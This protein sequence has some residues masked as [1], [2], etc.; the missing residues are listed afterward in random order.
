MELSR[1]NFIQGAGAVAATAAAAGTVGKALAKESSSLDSN[2]TS[3]ASGDILTRETLENGTWSFM[4]P[5]DPVSDD[6]ITETYTHDIVIVG[7]GMAGLCCAVS[8]AEQGADVI[9]FSASTKPVSRGG[10]NHAIGSKYQKEHGIDDSP[11]KRREQVMIDQIAGV[12][13]MDKRKWSRWINN[14]AEG[15]DWMID[16]MAAK[17]LKCSLEPAYNDVDG[18]LTSPA[19]SHNFFTDESPMGVF[20]GAPMIAQAYADWFTDDFGGEIDYS[21]VAEQL[22]RE[23]NNTG[24]VSA[25]I[26]K[27]ANGD[28][29]K[30]VANKAVV[31]ATGDFS[32]DFDMMAHFA[33]YAWEQFKDVLTPEIDYD[34]EMV[35]TGLMP[36]TGQKMGLWIGAA[37]QKTFPNPCAINGGVWGP[38]HCVIDNFWGINLAKDGKRFQNENTNF[39]F[40]AYSLMNLPDKTAYGIWD[41]NYAYTQDEWE[42]LGCTVD[43][44][45]GFVPATPEQLIASWDEAVDAGS[46]FKADTLDEL[47]AQLDG[48]DVEQAKK[49]IEHYNECAHD[50]YDDEYQVN[51]ELLFPIETGPFYASV[52]VGSTFLCVMGGL[53]CDEN[54]Q[55]LDA[56]DKPIE[57]LYEVGTMIGDFYS[58]AYNFAIPGQNL[59]ACCGTFPYLLGR[60]LAQL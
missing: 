31:L 9:V 57:G 42:T 17:G 59:G 21:T 50:G 43:N 49:S 20:T 52:S 41:T 5:P 3:A 27:N 19:A 1:R 36:G 26:A 38:T 35:Y 58:G 37:W 56:D 22:V 47:L 18:V 25:V 40:G 60:D 24:R 16:K 7:S 53:R 46:Y 30:Y 51:P 23:N 33:P 44:E 32:K 54:L 15:M 8:A 10:S 34:A 28:Y 12:R 29:V 2:S 55:V 14:S 48:L 45:N 11:E 4:V 13:M 39:A 6:Q